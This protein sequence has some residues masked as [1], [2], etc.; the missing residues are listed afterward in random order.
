[1]A[2]KI[3]AGFA[4]VAALVVAIAGGVVMSL[5]KSKQPPQE[6]AMTLQWFNY[7]GQSTE[8]LLAL[9][10]KY[11]TDSLVCAFEDAIQKKADAVGEDHISQEERVVFAV[12]ALERE[13]N[14]GGYDQFFVNSSSAYAAIIVDSLKR[15]GATEAANLTQEAIDALKIE[16][17]L[18]PENIE[19]AILREDEQR[20]NTLSHCDERYYQ[21][22]GD[23]AGPLL[24]FIKTNK[25]KIQPTGY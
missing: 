22:V 1:M 24:E 17:E 12:E 7:S 19:E 13:V 18:T 15:I 21:R 4:V 25:S 2:L 23:M 20:D 3:G 5:R 10:G 11:R 16:G 9:E 8:E 14:N 6:Q